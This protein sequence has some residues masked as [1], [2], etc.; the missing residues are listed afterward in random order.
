M[1]Q[2][3]IAL[4]YSIDNIQL[5]EQI[6]Q[7]LASVGHAPQHYYGSKSSPDKSLFEQLSQHSGPILLLITD[8]FLR[9]TQCMSGGR[10]FMQDNRDAVLPIV[11]DGIRQDEARNAYAVPTQ[12]ERISDIIQYINYWQDQYLDLR[13]QKREL[14][15]ELDETTFNEHLRQVRAISGE[16][17]EFLRLLRNTEH[18]TFEELEE[19]HFEALFRF[20]GDMKAWESLKKARLARAMESVPAAAVGTVLEEKPEPDLPPVDLR[21]IPGMNLLEDHETEMVPDDLEEIQEDAFPISLGEADQLTDEMPSEEF[22]TGHPIPEAEENWEEEEEAFDEEEEEEEEVAAPDPDLILAN[23]HDWVSG[24]QTETAIAQLQAALVHHPAHLAMRYQL[25]HLLVK[26]EDDFSEA[27]RQLATLLK[28][29]SKHTAAL[30]LSGE[31]SEIEE[32]FDEA[33]GFYQDV[34]NI[35][36]QFPEVHYRLGL[37]LAHQFEDTQEHALTEFRQAVEQDPENADAHYQYG[38]LLND[39]QNDPEAAAIEFRETLRLQPRHPFAYYD[40]ALL[41]HAQGDVERARAAYVEAAKLN[42]EVQ[43]PENDIAFGVVPAAAVNNS[44]GLEVHQAAAPIEVPAATPPPN[45]N[46]KPVETKSKPHMPAAELTG[47]ESTIERN[48]LAALKENILRLEEMIKA[49]DEEQERLLQ[50]RPGE[51]KTVMITGATSGIGKATAE[52]FASNGFRLILTGR[53]SDRLQ[54]LEDSWT[55]EYHTDIMSLQFDVRNVS[56]VEAAINALPENWRQIDILI[57]NAGKAKG[58]DPIHEGR[59]EHWEEMIDTNIKGLLY[60]TRAIAPAMV[61]RREGHIINICSTAGKEV[62][63]NGNVYCATKHAV[64]ALTLGMRLDLH[65]YN[66]RVSQVAPAHVEETE[67][68]EVRFD[69]DKARGAKVYED[70]QPLRAQDVAETIYFIA[71]RPAHVNVQDVVMLGTQQASSTVIDRSGR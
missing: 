68:A 2:Q 53:R 8:N 19:T 45:T 63:P 43:T 62:Y 31:L 44:N 16:T 66:I 40:L 46:T 33:A 50:Q 34:A 4:A 70:F 5:A 7:E 35:D 12:F 37:I 15:N 49:R 3:H 47:G 6:A 57:N 42:P 17:S 65:K 11:A 38:M 24:G 64:D 41:Y 10:E 28:Y 22:D 23:L 32:D 27:R 30:F 54:A 39:S 9:S 13:R 61:A 25:A 18:V 69:G 55:N 58:L 36:P 14:E 1:E 21:D 26:H 52:L 59:L 29:D 56:E 20:V 48:A 71:T 60:L 67:F 51:G